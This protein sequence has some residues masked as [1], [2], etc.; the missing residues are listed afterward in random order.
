MSNLRTSIKICKQTLAVAMAKFVM[1]HGEDFSDNCDYYRNE[2]GID[3]D[4]EDGVEVLKVI[5]IFNNGGCYFPH[6]SCY[7]MRKPIELEGDETMWYSVAF[8]CLYV[9]KE[10]DFIRLK[11]YALENFGPEYNSDES[12]P[13]HDYVETLSLQEL[14]KLADWLQCYPGQKELDKFVNECPSL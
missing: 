13:Y 7:Q 9:V 8:H 6:S 1:Q 5:D 2:F 11:F 12:E 4:M 10:F 3:E 14:E